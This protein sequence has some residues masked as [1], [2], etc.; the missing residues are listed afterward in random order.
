MC[1]KIFEYCILTHLK[2]S[3]ILHANQFGF[4]RHISTAV[5]AATV[6]KE[7]IMKYNKNG[8]A[9]Y[10]AFLDLTKAFDKVNHTILMAKLIDS[11]ESPI[12]T[13]TLINMYNKQL[14]RVCFNGNQSDFWRLGN[15]VRQGGVISPLLFNL[16]INN[17]LLKLS[18]LNEGC[19]LESEKHNSQA[20]ADDFTLLA[21]SANA[22]QILL[23][24][25]SILFSDLN[26]TLNLNK[27][28]CITAYGFQLQK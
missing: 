9:V 10:T 16:Y 5:M 24:K 28:V 20:Y 7:V 13:N 11:N 4:R 15:D 14:V 6:L 18:S 17:V 2:S 8:S 1:L 3:I 12:V 21:P 27:C 26:L 22:V 19:N 23:N 25:I